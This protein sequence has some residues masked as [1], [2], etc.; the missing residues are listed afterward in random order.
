MSYSVDKK[1]PLNYFKDIME[2]KAEMFRMYLEELGSSLIFLP[3][4]GYTMVTSKFYS[5]D[6]NEGSLRLYYTFSN[7]DYFWIQLNHLL[8]GN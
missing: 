5:Y 1:L 7:L 3:Y 4:C 2:E 6:D 8:K